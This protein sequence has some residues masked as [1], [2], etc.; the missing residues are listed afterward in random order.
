MVLFSLFRPF[1]V[2]IIEKKSARLSNRFLSIRLSKSGTFLNIHHLQHNEK[3]S[4]NPQMIRYGTSEHSD[5]NS[6]AYLF[7]PNGEGKEIP[8]GSNDFIRI[9]RGP[10]V[11]RIH[12]LHEM[13][14]VQYQ[15]T[16]TNGQ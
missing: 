9:Q 7:L 8:L 5:H 6:G 11:S 4:F 15:L 3:V 14:G 2:N 1:P 10:L 12:V 16:N 13:Y